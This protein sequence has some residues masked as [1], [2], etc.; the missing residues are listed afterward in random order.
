MEHHKIINLL[1]KT[2]DTELP[3]YATRKWVEI[4]D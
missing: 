1:S 3:R 4:R 2:S